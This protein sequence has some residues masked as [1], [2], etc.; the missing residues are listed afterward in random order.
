MVFVRV[1]VKVVDYVDVVDNGVVD[2]VVETIGGNSDSS[3]GLRSWRGNVDE[4]WMT[5]LLKRGLEARR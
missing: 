5:M 2:V 3:S 1:G 4:S